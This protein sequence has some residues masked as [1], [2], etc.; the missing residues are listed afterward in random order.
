MR[1]ILFALLFSGCLG[2][3]VGE[4]TRA[5]DSNYRDIIYDVVRLWGEDLTLPGFTCNIDKIY[6][7]LPNDAQFTASSGGFYCPPNE[8]V[9]C[10]TQ[11]AAAYTLQESGP[12]GNRK[13][14]LIVLA[15]SLNQ[16]E[17]E[18]AVAHETLHV[19]SFCTGHTNDA[20]DGG[21]GYPW[22]NGDSTHA[23]PRL[24]GVNGIL[25]KLGY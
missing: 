20:L 1:Y 12:Y 22:F 23:D 21:L 18:Y 2:Y 24:W 6:I 13:N 7:A 11:V 17:R 8:A 19:L 9:T 15:A 10:T 3:D 25:Y 14:Y 4:R 16:A 5:I